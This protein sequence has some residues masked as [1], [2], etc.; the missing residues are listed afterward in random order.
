MNEKKE[1][2]I[3]NLFTAN[4]SSGGRGSQSD[5]RTGGDDKRVIIDREKK[6]SIW[7]LFTQVGASTGDARKRSEDGGVGVDDEGGE[8]PL[9]D[10]FFTPRNVPNGKKEKE[11]AE[12][13]R[14]NCHPDGCHDRRE[15][16]PRVPSGAKPSLFRKVHENQDIKKEIEN[17]TSS[18][19]R[20]N[21]ILLDDKT[22]DS[23]L[24]SIISR[25]RTKMNIEGSHLA[26]CFTPP[27]TSSSA[28]YN[29]YKEFFAMG[30]SSKYGE[31]GKKVIDKKTLLD[32]LAQNKIRYQ[33]KDDNVLS[34]M[35]GE[36]QANQINQ[37]KHVNEANC[38]DQTKADEKKTYTCVL[39]K[40]NVCVP[41]NR[42][43]ENN[44]Q[45][46]IKMR[47]AHQILFKKDNFDIFHHLGDDLFRYIISNVK[48][49]K[50]LLL[51][52]RRF[53]DI[54]RCLR[55]KLIYDVTLKNTIPPE[56]IIKTVY[57]S[58]N[59]QVLDLSGC[60]HLTSHHFHLFCNS[61]NIKFDKTLKILCL[62]GCNKITDS[63][64]KDL[65]HRFKYLS[66][67]DVRNCYKISHDGIYPLKFKT[68]LVK[69]YL[70]NTTSS[71]VSNYHSDDTLRVLFTCVLPSSGESA[72]KGADLSSHITTPL[73]SLSCFE[74]TNAKELSDISYLY[75]ISKNLKVLNLRGC[76]INDTVAIFFKCF[77]NLIAL[78]VADT[79]VSN[80]VIKTVCAHSPKMR[81]LDISKTIDV[82]NDTILT[83][84]RN[85][86]RLRK[87]KLSSLQ[88]VDNFS[89]REFLKHCR[90]LVAIDFSNC[91]K[92]NNSFCNVNG[93]D[94]PSGPKLTDV[95]VYQCS[96][97]R[98][99]CEG[100]LTEV[101]C[102]SV[103]V[104][105]YNE[106]KIFETS[107]YAD[108]D[109]LDQSE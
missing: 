49:K 45:N 6:K 71:T 59:L 13:S 92:V 53:R 74:I 58:D 93:L 31:E 109:T 26:A 66:I 5:G 7:S 89:V 77:T 29:A 94:V 101:G 76:N 10:V 23:V 80:E 18:F 81:I 47:K 28:S 50:N 106:L 16:Y 37:T 9:V 52:N 72:T 19:K 44:H 87:I 17:I 35:K 54:V 64:L 38:T 73:K 102:S 56:S 68:G 97:D 70:G 42:V 62:N 34:R 41:V 60:S 22:E 4:R 46:V 51:L 90:G 88:N 3:A 36:K 78:N 12:D 55:V 21:N 91:W 84:A 100:A 103:R 65:L 75:A 86:K 99:V 48:N 32:D 33:I 82:H 107:I 15:D 95:G 108:M 61:H 105:I 63:S 98:R 2:T 40:K 43:N 25:K 24:N 1:L 69:L 20:K 39:K 8:S 57:T 27:A 104:H 83:V 67:V 11:E 79:K 96:V 14:G 30:A 85:L